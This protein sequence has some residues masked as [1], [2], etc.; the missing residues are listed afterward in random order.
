VRRLA[1]LAEAGRLG[2][3]QV[4]SAAGALGFLSGRCGCGWVRLARVRA[5]AAGRGGVLRSPLSPAAVAFWR[6]NTAAVH[7]DLAAAAKAGAPP[8]P[9]L[10]TLQ[11]A[12]A[13]DVLAG[14]RAGLA[15]GERPAGRMTCSLNL[16]RNEG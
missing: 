16:L 6:G 8:A 4:R 15:R 1:A 5:L 3:E 9:S 2:A 10:S 11:R 14:D 13:R 7:R 12:V